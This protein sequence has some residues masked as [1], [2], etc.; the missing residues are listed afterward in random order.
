MS[1][2]EILSR[3]N[4]RRFAILLAALPAG[5]CFQ[6]LYGE[7]AH[8]GLTADMRAIVVAP[9]KDRIGH[10]LGN[11]L[12][13]NLNGT[14]A[15][16]EPKYRLTVTT[17]LGTQTPT[18]S[19]QIQVA[20][21]AT[22]TGTAYYALAPAGGGETLVIGQAIA[23]AVYDRTEERFANLR[24]ERDAEI[25]LAKSLADEIELRLAAYLGD[26]K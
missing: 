12:I 11:D 26:K 16:V 25:K 13:A 18:V 4:W 23:V 21:A 15:V 9:I 8:P 1:L 22:V 6:P 17:T 20:N 10:Y 2:S 7:A 5:G 3:E 24:A 14:G 19:S